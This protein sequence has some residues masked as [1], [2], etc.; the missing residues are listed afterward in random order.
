MTR[1]HRTLVL[2]AYGRTVGVAGPEPALEMIRERL[3]PSYRGSGDSPQR[4]WRISVRGDMWRSD[5][6]NDQLALVDNV[7]TA[8]EIVLS[9]LE[10]WVGRSTRA[11]TSSPRRMCAPRG[12]AILIPGRSMSGKTSLTVALI[13][14]GASYW[15]DEYAVLDSRGMTCH[16]YPRRLAIRP[17]DGSAPHRIDAHDIGSPTG[18]GPRPVGLVAVMRYDAAAGWTRIDITRG[19][20]VLQLLDNTIPARSRP[21]A[22]LTA[23]QPP[24]ATDIPTASP[25]PAATRPRPP[26]SSWP[27]CETSGPDVPIVRRAHD[28]VHA[29]CPPGQRKLLS[30]RVG[31]D[32]VLYD[33]ADH[34][35]HL[36]S[37]PVAAVWRRL[38]G[39]SDAPEVTDAQ[40]DQAVAHLLER[41]LVVEVG[42]DDA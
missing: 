6:N 29:H 27:N 37:G 13:R 2:R 36:L 1:A 23:T 10:L 38:N 5:N 15:S 12:R 41:G 26:R 3:P 33:R 28:P 31:D 17:Y 35:V 8:S 9:D 42:A 30:R 32:V 21:R 39:D 11:G 16:P 18:H 24:R 34:D 14:A 22:V 19:Q 20:A 25:A 40:Q 7:V 4:R